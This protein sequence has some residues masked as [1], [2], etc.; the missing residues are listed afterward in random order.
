MLKFLNFILDP[1]LKQWFARLAEEKTKGYKHKE[2]V[3]TAMVESR[4]EVVYRTRMNL[5]FFG[6]MPLYIALFAFNFIIIGALV[7]VL[8]AFGITRC[9][10][11]QL[12]CVEIYKF[13]D[14][15]MKMK[16]GNRSI[17]YQKYKQIIK[18]FMSTN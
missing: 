11:K 8:W 17:E 18:D 14:H 9:Y 2:T 12:H 13:L 4:M 1:N 10:K 16:Y 15:S 3:V 5:I 7:F 6:L